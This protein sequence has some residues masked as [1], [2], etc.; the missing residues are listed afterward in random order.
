MIIYGSPMECMGKKQTTRDPSPYVSETRLP[1]TEGSL[2]RPRM[3]RSIEKRSTDTMG[4][5]G[6]S[7]RSMRDVMKRSC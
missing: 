1:E 3:T 7:T 2:S 5:Y 6:E 4:H